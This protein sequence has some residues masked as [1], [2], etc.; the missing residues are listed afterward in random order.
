MTISR[1]QYAEMLSR[2]QRN[3]KRDHPQ[4]A[5]P[6]AVEHES[7]LHTQIEDELKRRGWYYV[8]SRMDKPSTVAVGVPDFCIAADGG[9]AFFI[10]A[11]GRRTKVTPK[12]AGALLMLGNLGHKAALVRSFTEF[13]EVVK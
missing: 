8:H 7:D 3:W 9:R 11:K 10:E 5:C 1:Q 2:G 12:Q 4:S 13:L 6:D